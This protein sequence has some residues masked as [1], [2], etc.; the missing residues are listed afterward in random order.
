MAVDLTAKKSN[1]ISAGTAAA[2]AI[3]NARAA[4][5]LLT[6]EWNTGGYSTILADADFIGS[7]S[8]ML[9]AD[10][11]ALITS[12]ATLETFWTS[13]NGTNIEKCCPRSSAV[14]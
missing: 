3:K 11:T 7:N 13:G 5:L 8:H 4:L 6:S 12:A 2:L 14:S 1:F 10:L 9:K